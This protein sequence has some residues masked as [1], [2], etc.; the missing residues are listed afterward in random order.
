[1]FPQVSS[2]SSHQIPPTLY[3][4][5]FASVL[6]PASCPYHPCLAS[7]VM[8]IPPIPPQRGCRSKVPT[9]DTPLGRGQRP[10]RAREAPRSSPLFVNCHALALSLGTSGNAPTASMPAAVRPHCILRSGDLKMLAIF[11]PRIRPEYSQSSAHCRRQT[12]FLVLK[13][14]LGTS[15]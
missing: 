3:V 13:Y 4:R 8:P 11:R 2:A 14:P 15:N 7:C 6:R 1:M 5:A 9:T 12:C 10:A